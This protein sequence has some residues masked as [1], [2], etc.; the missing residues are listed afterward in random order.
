MIEVL[1]EGLH[2]NHHFKGYYDI[3][4]LTS[5]VTLIKHAEL[6]SAFTNIL[7]DSGTP[8]FQPV[9]FEKLSSRGL[10]PEDINFILNTHFHLDHCGN[11]AFFP[12][13][14][15]MVGRSTLNYATGRARIFQDIEAM[16]YP[17]GIK[18][19]FVPGHTHDSAAYLYEESGIKY[20]CAG[21]AVREDII[22][23]RH[24]PHVH[25]PEKFIGSMKLIFDSADV[26][27]P[28]H[29]R[30]IKGELK[31]ELYELICGEWKTL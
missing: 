10:R 25:V 22:R 5:S 28:G 20:V 15:I 7:V 24:I 12:N 4:P 26:V 18:M 30:V 11:D 23:R 1:I 16:Q 6:D 29:G 8:K 9:I 3:D 14:T 19:F 31:K 27:I 21:D 2:D 13:A 17:A